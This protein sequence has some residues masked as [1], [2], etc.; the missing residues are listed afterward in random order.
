[1]LDTRGGDAQGIGDGPALT[2]SLVLL[3]LSPERHPAMQEGV[4]DD[5]DATPM[6]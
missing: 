3:R 4:L 1:M 6:R 2:T 5:K